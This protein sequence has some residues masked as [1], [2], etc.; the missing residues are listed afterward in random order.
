MFEQVLDQQQLELIDRLN[1]YDAFASA[2]YL[3]GGTGL[4]LHVGHRKSQDL[5]FFA[6]GDF[7]VDETRE[8]INS[9]GGSVMVAESGTVHAVIDSVKI[10]VLR[11]TFPLLQSLESWRGI[12]VASIPDIVCMKCVAVA[13]RSQRCANELLERYFD[14]E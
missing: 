2:Y 7:Y 5:D 11:Y 13:Q 4:A 10:S 3:A 8:V 12:R 14:E 1:Q 9:L 6:P